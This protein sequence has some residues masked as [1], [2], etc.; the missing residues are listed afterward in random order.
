M[1]GPAYRA[2]FVDVKRNLT[3]DDGVTLEVKYTRNDSYGTVAGIK[4][5][6]NINKGS[7]VSNVTWT[8]KQGLNNK[9]YIFTVTYYSESS[10]WKS[11]LRYL[12]A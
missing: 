4:Q 5:V 10:G 11:S 9:Y 6:R 3:F 12:Y 1:S 7:Q 8:Y 2:T